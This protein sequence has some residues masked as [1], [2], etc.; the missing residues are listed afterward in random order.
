MNGSDANEQ[1]ETEFHESMDDLELTMKVITAN[2]ELEAD[3]FDR[4]TK[5]R[6]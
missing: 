3:E 4:L 6:M 1:I 5:G 2:S